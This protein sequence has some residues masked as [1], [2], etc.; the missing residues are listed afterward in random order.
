MQNEWNHMYIGIVH[1]HITQPASSFNV[2]LMSKCLG[3][4][5]WN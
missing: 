2:V 5:S 4:T 1:I 3:L